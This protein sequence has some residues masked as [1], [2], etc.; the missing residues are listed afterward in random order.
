MNRLKQYLFFILMISVT[1]AQA[2]FGAKAGLNF[3]VTGSYG[4]SEEGETAGFKHG[5]Q[6]GLFYKA[7]ISDGF[8]LMFEL[9]YEARGTV[10]KK[11]YTIQL[12]V[13]DPISGSVLGIGDYQIN[14][15]VNSRQTY[16]NIPILALLGSGNLKVYVGPNVG[17]LISGNAD[18][19]R[20]IDISLAGNTVGK[21]E[22]D[23][24]VDWQDYD[25]FKDI[26][27]T[28]PSE[29]GDFLNSLDFG[30]NLGAMY[31][32]GAG[33]IVDLRVSQ[34]LADSTNDHYD[35]SIYPAED[36]TFESRGDSDRNFSIQFGLGYF[37]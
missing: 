33:F 20:T 14:Q 35:N 1:T 15:E 13:Q 21:V 28:T 12:P 18:F 25:S 17:F 22:T 10:S 3:S 6:G 29:D 32:V 24:E 30:I 2:Q 34:G 37:F 9:N 7:G 4:N 36:F 11:D 8:N 27:T 19:K 31:Y 16:V 26:F 5:F 23:L